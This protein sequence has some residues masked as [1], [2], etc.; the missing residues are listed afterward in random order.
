MVPALWMRTS[1]LSPPSAARATAKI[2][3]SLSR[4]ATIGTTASPPSPAS[5]SRRSLLRPT[6]RTR[7]P[8]ATRPSAIAR[9]MPLLAPVTTHLL[10]EMVIL[11]AFSPEE[12]GALEPFGR[13]PDHVE[14]KTRP[15]RDVEK[16]VLAVGLVEHPQQRELLRVGIATSHRAVQPALPELRL[17][18]RREV[19][20]RRVALERVH[21]R[22]R[23]PERLLEPLRGDDVEVVSRGVVAGELGLERPGQTPDG[24]VEAGGVELPLVPT[25]RDEVEHP[26]V[27]R[28]G[29]DVRASPVHRRVT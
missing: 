27:G 21:D 11:S 29:H 6:A 3:S 22:E 24:K 9:P 1:T 14:W 5:D 16:R 28:V 12:P 15:L 13:G 17:S 20:V 7:P 10:P 25:P 23:R 4:S 26:P 19:S 2:P 18:S 8:A